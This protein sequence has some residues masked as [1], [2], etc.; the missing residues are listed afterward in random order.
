MALDLLVICSKHGW[1]S[2]TAELIW[3][4]IHSFPLNTCLPEN[5]LKKS[6]CLCNNYWIQTSLT[7]AVRLFVPSTCHY[8]ACY[9]QFLFEEKVPKVQFRNKARFHPCQ[10][11]VPIA[12]APFPT[13]RW[14]SKQEDEELSHESIAL[15]F[16]QTDTVLCESNS[17]T[18]RKKSL[19]QMTLVTAADSGFI[20]GAA[21]GAEKTLLHIYV[22]SRQTARKVIE[23]RKPGGNRFRWTWA[24][25]RMDKW[26]AIRLIWNRALNQR[27]TFLRKDATTV[28]QNW[29][30]APHTRT[31]KL[32]CISLLSIPQEHKHQFAPWI[33]SRYVSKQ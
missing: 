12:G 26:L 33:G 6:H 11:A 17:K 18:Q 27:Y 1:L 2:L 25:L 30:L 21:D 16:S 32:F 14:C 20:A 15:L 19:F 5:G 8:V 9:W 10:T 24:L 7:S 4:C 31:D 28:Y 23:S 13:Q 29:R 22:N 3:V